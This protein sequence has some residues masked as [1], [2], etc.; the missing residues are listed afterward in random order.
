[1]V[2]RAEHGL[3]VGIAPLRRHPP[4]A[5]GRGG[6]ALDAPGRWLP[7][8]RERC[9]AWTLKGT[10]IVAEEGINLF[11]AGAADEVDAFLRWLA[12]D[13]AFVDRDGRPA[14]ADLDV[15]RSLS[16]SPPFKRLR[17]KQ[18]PEIVTM[19]RPT[20]RPQHG[21]APSITPHRLA[22]W[23]AQ[24]HDDRGRPIVLLDTRNA[25][26]FAHGS[27][28]GARHLNLVQFDGFPAAVDAVRDDLRDRTIVTFCTGGIRCEKA[29]LYMRDTGYERVLQLDGGILRYFEQVGDAHWHGDCFVFDERRTLSSDLDERA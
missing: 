3:P 23:L 1:M 25:F 11:L 15:K 13:P 4:P 19:R 14:F 27:F 21:R 5:G 22:A 17:V 6:V 8:L 2:S 18:K 7:V 9:T 29:A 26:E 24:G 20:I 28:D 12:T 10:I 16:A